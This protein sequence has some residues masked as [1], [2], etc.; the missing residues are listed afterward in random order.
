MKIFETLC[1]T[2]THLQRRYEC[3]LVV[4]SVATTLS[5]LTVFFSHQ[6]TF[7]DSRMLTLVNIS[8]NNLSGPMDLQ[9]APAVVSLDASHNN[10]THVK[11]FKKYKP[12]Q[13]LRSFDL[14]SNLISQEFASLFVGKPRNLEEI[15][16]SNNAISGPVQISEQFDFLRR[17]VMGSNRLSGTLPNLPS[18]FPNL[19]DLDLSSNMITGSINGGLTNHLILKTLDLS[20][21]MLTSF[22]EVAVLSNLVQLNRMDLSNNELGPTIPREI[23]KLK[24][25][26]TMLDLS[27]NNFRSR[28]PSELGSL[29]SD[30]TVRLTG[31]LFD[32]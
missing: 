31:N 27:N 10:F 23:G 16:L 6:Y 25:K 13:S 32:K 5:G 24:D 29:Q 11:R 20:G 12:S 7:L 8:H 22:D 17:L 2:G 28:I 21:N 26:L 1:A 3:N 19:V 14:S 30:A 9:F 4:W 15:D 18:K